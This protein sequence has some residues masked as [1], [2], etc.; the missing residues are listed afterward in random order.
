MSLVKH[1]DNAS[2]ALFALGF[3]I[4]K[5]KHVPNI[6]FATAIDLSA[7]GIY[8]SAYLLWLVSSFIHPDRAR[9][10][11]EWY[12]FAQFREQHLLSASLGLVA[13]I[14]SI[15]AIYFPPLVVP[16]AWAFLISNIIW[17]IS[18]Y[19]KLNNPSLWDDNFS[20]RQQYSY[21]TYAMALTMIS[22]VE[23][24]AETLAL[25]FPEIALAIFLTSTIL[26]IATGIYAVEYWVDAN[27]R[28]DS[29][30]TTPGSYSLLRSALGS[31]TPNSSVS[32]LNPG[33]HV[34]LFSNYSPVMQ[35]FAPD[36][37]DFT[38]ISP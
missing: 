17:A 31:N 30:S 38:C 5:I 10:Q 29:P 37:N 6:I 27:F 36:S 26:S 9:L 20:R 2:S 8:S 23:A 18:E 11:K 25:C 16:T 22:L 1:L 21:V 15:I 32:L 7:L 34:D 4:A 3:T 28:P 19:H 13:C 12:G 33:P 14:M 35:D 24:L